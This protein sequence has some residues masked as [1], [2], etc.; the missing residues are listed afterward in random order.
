MGK[1]QI[2]EKRFR[3]I[4]IEKNIIIPDDLLQA[5]SI[6]LREET[7]GEERRPIGIILLEMGAL[8]AGQIETVVSESLRTEAKQRIRKQNKLH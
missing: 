2:Y 5:L 1:I 4:A 3:Q 7:A 6:Q 8:N